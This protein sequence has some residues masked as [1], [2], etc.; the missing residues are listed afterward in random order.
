MFQIPQQQ[1]QQQLQP[2]QQ[3]F[4]AFSFVEDQFDEVWYI[5]LS[6]IL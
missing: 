6:F 5:L 4:E 3:E 1:Q 2:Q